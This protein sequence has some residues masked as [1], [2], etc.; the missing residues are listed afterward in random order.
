MSELR[1]QDMDG[2][3]TFRIDHSAEPGGDILDLLASVLVDK[4]EQEHE[5]QQA[6]GTE[7]MAGA[8]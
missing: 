6:S 2:R 3:F 7:G 5:R 8:A 1:T 4:W